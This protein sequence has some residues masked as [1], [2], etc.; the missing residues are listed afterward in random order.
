MHLELY[1]E[2][3]LPPLLTCVLT[4]RLGGAPLEDHW[5][6]REAAAAAVAAVVARYGGQPGNLRQRVAKQLVNAYADPSKS[7][8][9][10]YGA[11]L[12]HHLFGVQPRV[13]QGFAEIIVS[14]LAWAVPSSPPFSM[15][16]RLQ[17]LHT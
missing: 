5:A 6:V 12:A 14:C 3:L 2:S 13:F 11:P 10:H 4:K 15:H 9:C 1:L 8:A 7:L 17:C 16:K